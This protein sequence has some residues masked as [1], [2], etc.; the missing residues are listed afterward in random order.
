[1]SIKFINK[2]GQNTSDATATAD[3]IIAPKTAYVNGEKVEGSIIPTYVKSGLNI[4]KETLS[5]EANQNYVLDYSYD[6]NLVISASSYNNI[7]DVVINNST[8]MKSINISEIDVNYTNFQDAK[9]YGETE[10]NIQKIILVVNDG[11]NSYIVTLKI[12]VLSLEITEIKIDTTNLL[13]GTDLYGVKII[14][15]PVFT[16]VVTIAL[17]HQ[18][19]Y[20]GT[21]IVHQFKVVSD[22]YQL[23]SKVEIIGSFNKYM[24]AQNNFIDMIWSSN[25]LNLLLIFSAMNESKQRPKHT[26]IIYYSYGLTN[27]TVINTD[28]TENAPTCFLNDKYFIKGSNIYN[29]ENQTI[30][31]YKTLTEIVSNNISDYMTVLNDYYLIH[32]VKDN[33]AVNIYSYDDDFNFTFIKSYSWNITLS[34]PAVS[35][36][37]LVF[38]NYYSLN[39]ILYS[40]DNVVQ[41]I[42]TG[43]EPSNEYES[44]N[45][46]G[47][48][49]YN[50][51]S[52]ITTSNKILKDEKVFTSVGKIKGTMPN[53]GALNYTPT[54]EAQT[55]PAGY[56]SGGTVEAMDITNSEDYIICNSLAKEILGLDSFI[57]LEYIQSTGSQYIDLGVVATDTTSIYIEFEKTGTVIDYERLLSAYTA[58][59]SSGTANLNIQRDNKSGTF[60]VIVCNKELTT[61]S[62]ANNTKYTLK[63]GNGSIYFNNELKCYYTQTISEESEY[64]LFHGNDRYGIFKIYHCTIYDGDTI[65]KDFVPAMDSNNVICL[66]DRINKQYIYANENTLNGGGVVID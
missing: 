13:Y 10:N 45:I 5:V 22:S 63:I 53:N 23:L 20:K 1:M 36:N 15:N 33:N 61:I 46:V 62:I 48:E 2:S 27:A 35:S 39:R 43:N 66:Y 56:T 12:N 47:I 14:F 41:S 44:L 64:R 60:D 65:V 6:N 29:Y 59:T 17:K 57:Q 16:D 31:L 50:T 55:I 24:L 21:A 4:S 37:T 26:Y 9:F 25:G 42:Y 49:Y 32:F 19:N 28:L 58:H 52:C 30:T 38:A 34:S 54:T 11:S 51:S 3:D 18:K 8:S 40:E 7:T